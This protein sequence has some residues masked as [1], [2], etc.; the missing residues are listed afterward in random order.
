MQ[1]D[2]ESANIGK[3]KDFYRDKLEMIGNYI[4]FYTYYFYI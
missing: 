3:L 2:F 1:V 4:I